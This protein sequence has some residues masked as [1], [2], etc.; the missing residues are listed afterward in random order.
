MIKLIVPLLTCIFLCLTTCSGP[1]MTNESARYFN[2]AALI[3]AEAIKGNRIDEIRQLAGQVNL[4]QFHKKN[5]TLLI[6]AMLMNS[7]EAFRLLLVAGANPNLKDHDNIQP[8]ALAA[9]ARDNNPYLKLLLQYGG[10]PNSWQRTKPALHV[11]IDR[12]Y[13]QNV[14]LLLDAGGDINSRDKNGLTLLNSAGYLQD[15]PMAL[16]FIRRG[17]DIT[18]PTKNGGGIALSVQGGTPQP[19]SASYKAQIELKKL[20]MDRGV[21]FP[22]FHPSAT[23]YTGLLDRWHKTPGGQQWQQKLKQLGNDPLGVG[24]RWQQADEAAF[25][26]FKAWMKTNHIAEPEHPKPATLPLGLN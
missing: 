13:N 25:A 21:T 19:G 5:M 26:A 2:G 11:A 23:P 24:E 10:D 3:L 8:V 4:N 9:G 12:K 17:A 7:E 14:I 20:L 22:I 6:W 1:L 16:E 18:I 15:F